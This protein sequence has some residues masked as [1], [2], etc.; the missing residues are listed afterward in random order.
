[1]CTVIIE[2]LVSS[3]TEDE[4]KSQPYRETQPAEWKCAYLTFLI[5]VASSNSS[6]SAE[7]YQN[8]AEVQEK[9]DVYI[10]CYTVLQY[11]QQG[12][13]IVMGTSLRQHD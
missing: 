6:V 12:R 8:K 2:A 11:V 3:L 13:N 1:M 4:G 7:E 9:L 5:G 10:E